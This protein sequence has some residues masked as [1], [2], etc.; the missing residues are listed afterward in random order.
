MIELA[1]PKKNVI[2]VVENGFF[3]GRKIF[4]P[5]NPKQRYVMIERAPDNFHLAC[6]FHDLWISNNG[7]PE[8]N[9]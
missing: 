4:V 7:C 9:K 1:T 3:K 8:C 2:G 5:D 6:L